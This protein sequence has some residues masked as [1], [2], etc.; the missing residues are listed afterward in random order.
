[1]LSSYIGATAHV[2]AIMTSH[3][4]GMSLLSP[5]EN[6]GKPSK[7][8]I[9]SIGEWTDAMLIY[10]ALYTSRHPDKLM[11]LLKY[12]S[13]VR[14]AAARFGT[15]GALDYD[16]R[17]R[18]KM[19][20]DPCRR[21]DSIDGES[22]FFL[23]VPQALTRHNLGGGNNRQNLGRNNPAGQPFHKNVSTPNRFPTG[24][25]WQF[26]RGHCNKQDCRYAHKCA[27]CS[28]A[29]PQ[30]LCHSAKGRGKDNPPQRQKPSKSE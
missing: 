12:V 15:K 26:N 29:H 11:Q 22:Y 28:Q 19:A 5:S 2:E 21:W 25:C 13:I 20:M 17:V 24:V 9:I 10:L 7:K 30:T 3:L 6:V 18:I 27:T 1:M 23:L 8:Q 14:E 4:F 16:R